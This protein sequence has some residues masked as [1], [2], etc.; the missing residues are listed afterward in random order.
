LKR[1]IVFPESTGQG[2]ERF[3]NSAEN[4]QHPILQENLDTITT[5]AFSPDGKTIGVGADAADEGIRLYDAVTGKHTIMGLAWETRQPVRT[6]KS[7]PAVV[8]QGV[9]TGWA[10]STS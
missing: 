2:N 7:E 3:R 6:I 5:V 8:F 1:N 10:P 4:L 9:T